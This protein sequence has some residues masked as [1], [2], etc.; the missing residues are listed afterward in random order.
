MEPLLTPQE[1]ASLLKISVAAVRE[2]CRQ[3]TQV[4]SRCPLPCLRLHKKAIRFRRSDVEAWLQ[5]MAEEQSPQ[6]PKARK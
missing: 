4:R 3:R 1:L 5:K 6:T 2:L